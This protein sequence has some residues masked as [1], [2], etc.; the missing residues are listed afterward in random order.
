MTTL[1]ELASAVDALI[2]AVDA[3]GMFEAGSIDK[4]DELDHLLAG[5]V[6]DADTVR[7]IDTRM[8]E[9]WSLKLADALRQFPLLIS[10]DNVIDAASRSTGEQQP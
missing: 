3:Y 7:T 5:L 4:R 2:T 1:S 10:L 9:G 8:G 6:R